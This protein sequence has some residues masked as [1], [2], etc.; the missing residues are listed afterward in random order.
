VIWAAG[1]RL[2]S[3]INI[4]LA[5]LERIVLGFLRQGAFQR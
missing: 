2:H 1:D 3:V 5:A 4:G